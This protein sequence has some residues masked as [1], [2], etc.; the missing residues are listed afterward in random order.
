ML[1]LGLIYSC[2]PS[3]TVT[4]DYDRAV[5]FSEFKTSAIYDLKTQE[6]QINQLNVEM[7]I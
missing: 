1:L 6:G 5:S 2:A 3:V 7:I 4:T